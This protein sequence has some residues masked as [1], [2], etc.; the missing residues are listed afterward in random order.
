VAFNDA[1]A[2]GGIYNHEGRM[3][4]ESVTV[5]GNTARMPIVTTAGAGIFSDLTGEVGDSVT[6][7]KN[8]IV[9]GN[10]SLFPVY[11]PGYIGESDVAG[12]IQSAGSNLIQ[13]TVGATITPPSGGPNPGDAISIGS[14]TI[15]DLYGV[16]ARLGP[17]QNNGG[18]TRTMALLVDSPAIGTGDPVG[19]P[20]IDQR[21]L[22]R[23]INDTTDIGAYA[24][25]TTGTPAVEPII[26]C[27]GSNPATESNP[28]ITVVQ[29][30]VMVIPPSITG[31]GPRIGGGTGPSGA[32]AAP[33]IT[34][35]SLA[36]VASP[37]PRRWPPHG[38]S[39]CWQRR[40]WAPC[41]PSCPRPLPCERRQ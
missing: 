8:T 14:H 13:S 21:G 5:A 29:P 2:G 34:A 20:R 28:P 18:P 23:V 11:I 15:R 31:T 37:T 24:S 22:T 19:A 41:P 40:A 16:A 38:R 32:T 17:L 1:F 36:A 7:L 4:L 9:A 3:V 35:V 27:D 10:R 6:S 25:Q 39:G 33:S 26:D 30:P 12:P